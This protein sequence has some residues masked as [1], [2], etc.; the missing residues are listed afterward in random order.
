MDLASPTRPCLALT[1][2]TDSGAAARPAIEEMT[3]TLPR[4]AMSCGRQARA[5]TR[6]VV[7]LARQLRSQASSAM[8]P[9]V[10]MPFP[11]A[12]ATRTSMPPNR[13]IAAPA[14]AAMAAPSAASAGTASAC[15]LGDEPARHR[16]ADPG[17]RAGDH[18]HP[19]VQP[20]HDDLQRA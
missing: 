1:Y 5:A 11:P 14:T 17:P 8:S 6:Q 3:T 19:A 12:F 10:P 4:R 9:A 13:P 18:R 20:A 16:G 7:T 2:P 15:A